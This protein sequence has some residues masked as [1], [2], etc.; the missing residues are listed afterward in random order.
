MNQKKKELCMNKTFL[1]VLTVI[2][3]MTVG[4]S[5]N[6]SAGIGDWKNYTDMKNVV[7]LVSTRDVVWAGTGGGLLCFTVRDSAFK[8]FT[9][10]EGLSGNDVSAVG[11]GANGTVWIGEQSGAIDIL[12]PATNSWQYI[13][14]IDLST[15]PQKSINAFFSRGDSMYIATAFGVSLFSISKFEFKDTYSNFGSFTNPIVTSLVVYNG[16]I[17]AATSRGL[18]VSRPNAANLAA[19]ESWESFTSP[20]SANAV[21]AFHGNVYAATNDGLFVYLNGTWSMANGITQ[22]VQALVSTDSLLYIVGAH[23]VTTLSSSNVISAYGGAA[24]GTIACVALDSSKRLFAGLQDAGVGMLNSGANQWTQFIPNG[25]GSNFFSSLAVDEKGVVWAASAAGNGNGFSSFDGASW[26]NYN[27]GIMPQLNKNSYFNVSL[28]PNNSKWFGSWGGGLAV[29]NSAGDLVR[30]FDNTYPGFVGADTVTF[31]VV[32]KTATDRFGNVWASLYRSL[33]GNV[34]W[35]MKPDSEWVSYRTALSNSFNFILGITTD[36]NGTKWC[37]TAL[38]GATPDAPQFMY[39]NESVSVSGLEEDRWGQ[40]TAADGLTSASVTCVVEDKEGS[41]W[42]GTVVGITIVSDPLYPKSRISKIFLGAVRDLFINTIA[43][44]ALNN[45]WIG[46]GQGVMVLSPDG[47]TLLAQYNVIN[48]NGKLVDNN[49]LS[50]A[51]DEKRG[52]AYFGTEKGLSSLEIPAI[53]T[54]EK[55]ATLEIAPNPFILPDNSSVTIK[56]LAENSTIKILSVTGGLVKQFNAQGGGRAFWDGTDAIGNVVGS[57][58]YLVV[59]H[60]ENG[61][62]VATAKVAVLRR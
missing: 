56:G 13:R 44:D 53:A 14:D 2:W 49:V 29:V 12:S 25:P 30:V 35:K 31:V 33:N 3:A 40:L 4:V 60:A 21:A 20:A 41:L 18:A 23:N 51:F 55:L 50:I 24:P 61:N 52:I 39:F 5:T 62:Q 7:A 59:A 58:V 1:S 32:G 16:R 27:V 17:Y 11:L 8:K 34:L 46:S 36:R 48:T 54:L 15:K 38:P 28:G 47:T 6:A 57:G 42:V 10:S 43:V 26:R 19:P 37:W 45:K 22:A 9:N